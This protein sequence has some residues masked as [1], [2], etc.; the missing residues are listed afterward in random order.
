MTIS[1]FRGRLGLWLPLLLIVCCAMGCDNEIIHITGTG[2]DI[3]ADVPDGDPVD[4]DMTDSDVADNDIVDGDD[5][6]GDL[7]TDGDIDGETLP[8]GTLTIMLTN[9]GTD[10]AYVKYNQTAKLGAG[11]GG[12]AVMKGDS[13]LV[14]DS[15]CTM[16][17]EGGC[18]QIACDAP[19]DQLRQ[20]F[21]GE[22]MILTWDGGYYTFEDCETPT[23]GAATCHRKQQ[24][25][26]GNYTL[27]FCY[28]FLMDVSESYLP[29]RLAGDIL[30]NARV[31]DP[32]C[33]DIDVQIPE[34]AKTVNHVFYASLG[35]PKKTPGYCGQVWT[36]PL[37]QPGIVLQGEPYN[38]AEGS[39]PV[40]LLGAQF[41]E[42]PPCWR[43]GEVNRWVNAATRQ[44]NISASVFTGQRECPS[45]V[46]DKPLH[47]AII[48][49]LE[50]GDWT[51]MV[52]AYS[53]SYRS[54]HSLTVTA[55]PICL[56]CPDGEFSAIGGSCSAD[57]G[58][59]DGGSVCETSSLC[60]N[61]CL[62]ADDCP[63]GYACQYS[64]YTAAAVSACTTLREDLCRWDIECPKGHRCI[65]DNNSFKQCR[66]EMDTR[67]VEAQYGQGIACGCDAECPGTQSCVRF[68]DFFTDGF[69]AIVCRDARDC[70]ET[71][72]CSGLTQSGIASICRPPEK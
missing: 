6:D 3:D 10:A 36:W 69:C 28:S 63:A 70:P 57:C 35:I 37:A 58:C 13:T 68:E 56:E 59:K 51:V 22:A 46:F 18:M 45:G 34:T 24:V 40:Y 62:S 53:Y 15:S 64:E 67:M 60:M 65:E 72:E 32:I 31:A 71:W 7:I 33:A 38:V 47:A 55:C 17:C 39:S 43:W 20:I 50:A 29:V 11:N 19:P 21:P 30:D 16:P 44:A 48:P 41:D 8:A 27:H 5:I 42:A 14:V 66:R 26:A 49:P 52:G 23:G 54:T 12:I 4:S 2:G 61:Y 1:V 25:A 9:T